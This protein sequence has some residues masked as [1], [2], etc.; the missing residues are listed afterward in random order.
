MISRLKQ[1]NTVINFFSVLIYL[2]PLSIIIGNFYS[3]LI[4][5]VCS[6]FFFIYSTIKKKENFNDIFFKIFLVFWILIVARSLFT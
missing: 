1:N 3:N 6:L 5:T 4:V 2:F